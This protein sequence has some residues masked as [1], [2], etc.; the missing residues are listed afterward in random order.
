MAL[1]LPKETHTIG[2]IVADLSKAKSKALYNA[3]IK[4]KMGSR[5]LFYTIINDPSYDLKRSQGVFFSKALGV[6]I[7]SLHVEVKR[8]RKKNAA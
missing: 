3:F 8:M 5:N 4:C 7:E 2:E 1:I 6:P